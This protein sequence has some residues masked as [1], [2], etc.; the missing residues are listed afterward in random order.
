MRAYVCTHVLASSRATSRWVAFASSPSRSSAL[1]AA[2]SRDASPPPHR[3]PSPSPWPSANNPGRKHAR[4]S[5]LCVTSPKT[6]PWRSATYRRPLLRASPAAARARTN[7]GCRVSRSGSSGKTESQSRS[8]H[9]R[10]AF[11]DVP[12]PSSVE[13]VSVGGDGGDWLSE[14]DAGEAPSAAAFSPSLGSSPVPEPAFVVPAV[15][16]GSSA[17]LAA[18]PPK[19][20]PS[21]DDRCSR[22][23]RTPSIACRYAASPPA[24]RPECIQCLSRYS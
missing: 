17:S 7:R 12:D 19:T 5:C 4:W 11:F 21:P 20:S 1:A 3:R 16:A 22:C 10:R 23:I 15:P 9:R 8:Y 6:P 13:G 18:Y 14:G 2:A 24:G